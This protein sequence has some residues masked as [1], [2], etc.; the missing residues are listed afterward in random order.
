M[1]AKKKYI[2]L[3][4]AAGAGTRMKTK[5]EKPF[6]KIKQAPILVHTLKSLSSC[7]LLTEIIIV[8][9]P[10]KIKPWQRELENSSLKKKFSLIPGGKKRQDSVFNGFQALPD[11]TDIVLIHDGV[12]PLVTRD[13]LEK[14][15]KTAEK[16]GVAIPVVEIKP[17]IK[18]VDNKNF[19]VRTLNRKILKEV[20]TPQCFRYNILKKCLENNH[21]EVTDEAS[22]AENLGYKVKTFSGSPRNLKITTPEDLISAAGL[23]KHMPPKQ[24]PA[25]I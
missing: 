25:K 2:A 7:P 16:H 13:I 15:I 18:E 21:R 24:H 11:D 12:R 5:L 6:I 3:V 20:Q 19:V 1:T 17:T 22:L 9:N 8:V 14:G 10:R 23:L 4:P